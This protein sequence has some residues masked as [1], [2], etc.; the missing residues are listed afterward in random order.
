MNHIINESLIIEKAL[1][2]E[3]RINYIIDKNL[4]DLQRCK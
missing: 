4:N 3:K 1:T 2:I